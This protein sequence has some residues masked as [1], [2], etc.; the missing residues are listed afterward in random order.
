M[1]ASRV[2]VVTAAPAGRGDA[3]VWV[4][5]N[6]DLLPYPS[7][8]RWHYDLMERCCTFD[9]NCAMAWF[10]AVFPGKP[11]CFSFILE[12]EIV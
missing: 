8:G 2:D 7:E 4:R 11:P 9:G 1:E 3:N 5:Q 6:R 12:R 10:C